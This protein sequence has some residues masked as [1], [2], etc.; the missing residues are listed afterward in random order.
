MRKAPVWLHRR[1]RVVRLAQAV[2]HTPIPR[3]TMHEYAAAARLRLCKDVAF[4]PCLKLLNS[5]A[6][7]AGHL[8]G[9]N[10]AMSLQLEC[11]AVSS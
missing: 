5:L 3:L 4:Q 11:H 2:L 10:R 1:R 8:D 9:L 7:E 6:G